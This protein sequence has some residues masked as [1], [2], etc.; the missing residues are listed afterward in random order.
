MNLPVRAGQRVGDVAVVAIVR[1]AWEFSVYRPRE[2]CAGSP[3][4]DRGAQALE[5]ERGRLL[6]E[7]L[8]PAVA[9]AAVDRP[10]LSQGAALLRLCTVQR[11]VAEQDGGPWLFFCDVTFVSTVRFYEVGRRAPAASPFINSIAP[12]RS[13]I[14][15]SND[16][17]CPARM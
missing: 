3:E 2:S 8:L 16:V 12:S 6:P 14:H 13:G 1:A 5:E 17:P 15:S 7:R 10:A 4:D 9:D 11:D